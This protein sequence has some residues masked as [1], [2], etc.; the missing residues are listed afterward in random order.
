MPALQ[1]RALGHALAEYE[2]L[3]YRDQRRDQPLGPS[4]RG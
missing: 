3:N 1:A 2:L 4:S